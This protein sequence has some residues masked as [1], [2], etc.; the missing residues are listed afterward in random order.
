ML[1]RAE[2]AERALR[3]SQRQVE[4]VQ[5]AL[6]SDGPVFSFLVEYDRLDM[7]AEPLHGRRVESGGVPHPCDRPLPYL[8]TRDAR[9]MKRRVD[10]AVGALLSELT[11]WL[12][13]ERPPA[14]RC[15]CCGGTV[16]RSGRPPVRR[17]AAETRLI[18]L[19]SDGRLPERVVLG[20]MAGV[21]RSTLR[22]AAEELGVGR[23]LEGGVWFWQLPE[24]FGEEP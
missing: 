14:G 18:A 12:N 24:Q 4:P 17:R 16:D 9:A 15:L 22:R 7:A 10:R 23:V 21:P 20:Q 8:S 13:G 2:K 3:E 6:L 11:D 5:R 19:L 1:S